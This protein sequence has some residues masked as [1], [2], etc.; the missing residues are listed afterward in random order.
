MLL[1]IN[2]FKESL[3]IQLLIL[4]TTFCIIMIMM[5]SIYTNNLSYFFLGWNLFLA[6]VPL[7]FALIWQHR[8]IFSRYLANWKQ[9]ILFG[10]WLLFWPNAPYLIT[11]LIHLNKWF[12]PAEWLDVLLFF[13]AAFTGLVLGLYAMYKVHW[14][15]LDYFGSLRCWIIVLVC[16]LLSSYGIYLGR[17]LRWN[18]WDILS[19][20]ILLLQDAMLHLAM[21]EA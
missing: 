5:L 15:L 6:W 13:S 17:V 3:A 12:N 10:L 16:L 21:R 4:L 8:L 20:P 2:Y 7:F 14:I 19:N 9:L 1:F 11:D 18:S